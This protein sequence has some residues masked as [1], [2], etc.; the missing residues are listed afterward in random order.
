MAKKTSSK[1]VELP[2][3]TG[4]GVAPV[5]IP[6]LDKLCEKYEREKEKRCKMTPK[7]VAA[8]SDLMDA[9]HKHS[10]KLS[11]NGDGELFY[12]Y[13]D[14]DFVLQQGKETLK[15]KAVVAEGE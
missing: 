6:E 1:V 2:G 4:K 5:T 7:E 3:M 11:K 10:D 14:Q 12:R 8:K 9:M 13:N 15:V